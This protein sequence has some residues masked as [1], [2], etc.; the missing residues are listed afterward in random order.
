MFVAKTP[1]ERLLLDALKCTIN[2]GSLDVGRTSE[3]YSVWSGGVE[4]ESG[5]SREAAI[6]FAMGLERAGTLYSGGT[7]DPEVRCGPFVCWPESRWGEIVGEPLDE[8]EP[9]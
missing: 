4:I 5:L 7:H 3:N 9:R 8:V 1:R 6:G 2:G